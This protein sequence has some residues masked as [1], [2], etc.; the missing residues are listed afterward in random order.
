MIMRAEILFFRATLGA[1]NTIWP[2][3]RISEALEAVARRAPLRAG[4]QSNA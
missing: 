1:G 2:A 4:D 3:Q